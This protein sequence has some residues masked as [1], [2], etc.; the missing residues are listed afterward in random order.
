MVLGGKTLPPFLHAQTQI[1]QGYTLIAQ[2]NL[3]HQE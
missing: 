1:L 3:I 2:K